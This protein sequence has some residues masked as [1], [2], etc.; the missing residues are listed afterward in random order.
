MVFSQGKFVMPASIIFIVIF[1]VV[2]F[3]FIVVAFEFTGPKRKHVSTHFAD[4]QIFILIGTFLFVLL[5]TMLPPVEDLADC[6]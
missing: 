2:F 3:I 6:T 1:G 4:V 5:K